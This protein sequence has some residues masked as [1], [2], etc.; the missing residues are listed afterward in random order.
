[1]R[2]VALFWGTRMRIR[3][4]VDLR[5][6]KKQPPSALSIL[7]KKLT[8]TRAR[9]KRLEADRRT[10]AAIVDSSR[11]ALWSW[12]ANGTIVRWNAEAE[13]LFGYSAEEIIGQSLLT[14]IPPDRHDRAGE[15]IGK[16]LQ[17]QWYGQY[18]TV[19]V[20]K[21]GT[22]VDVELTV[23]PI[24]DGRGKIIGCLSSCRDISERRQFQASLTNRMR[25]L[26]TLTHFSERL[27]ATRQ[28]EAVY[29]ASRL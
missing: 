11:D 16:A 8:G 22:K 28:I 20:R 29:E 3:K 21:D 24:T 1:M 23:S 17:G 4:R 13:H 25:E 9:L 2:G 14:L 19:R 12:N 6:R 18:E 15:I 5:K 10:L 26:T 7:Q 27:Q